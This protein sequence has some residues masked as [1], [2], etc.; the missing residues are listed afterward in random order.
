MLKGKINWIP[1]QTIN[2]VAQRIDTSDFKD[3]KQLYEALAE[4][5]TAEGFV[6]WDEDLY[7]KE[8]LVSNRWREVRY[9]KMIIR[10]TKRD[11]KFIIKEVGVS[12][13]HIKNTVHTDL[14]KLVYARNH[15]RIP[16]VHGVPE[17]DGLKAWEYFDGYISKMQELGVRNLKQLLK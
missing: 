1:V 5:L 6:L 14:D 10:G 9:N 3:E 11:N 8:E 12:Y 15:L 13:E 7:F 16:T 2:K 17:E 4:H